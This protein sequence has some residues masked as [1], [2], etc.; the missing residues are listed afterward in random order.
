[1]GGKRGWLQ[2][3][4]VRRRDTSG[5]G[6]RRSAEVLIRRICLGY[7]DGRRVCFVPEAEEEFL[8]RDDVHRVVGMMHTGSEDLEWRLTEP[9]RHPGEGPYDTGAV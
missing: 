9:G 7:E 1:M 5:R 8:S 2:G 3:V 6:E 4:E